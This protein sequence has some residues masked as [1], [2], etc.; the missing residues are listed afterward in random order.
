M[1]ELEKQALTDPFLADALEGASLVTAEE[2]AGDT[3][4]LKE[5]ILFSKKSTN[6]WPLRIAAS[7][8]LVAVTAI[9]IYQYTDQPSEQNLALNSEDIKPVSESVEEESAQKDM[10]PVTDANPEVPS[11]DSEQTEVVTRSLPAEGVREDEAADRSEP[12]PQPITEI[13]E[14]GEMEE[15]KARRLQ[16]SRKNA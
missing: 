6:Y 14:G 9:L 2:F 3:N 13:A 15:K 8:A 16:M 5:K 7:I 12:S 1:H 11:E 10:Q 4:S